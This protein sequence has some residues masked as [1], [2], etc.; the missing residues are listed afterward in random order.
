[1]I[2]GNNNYLIE[3]SQDF[4]D[5]IEENDE[6]DIEGKF[7]KKCVIVLSILSALLILSS[8]GSSCAD[9]SSCLVMGDDLFPVKNLPLTRDDN[10]SLNLQSILDNYRYTENYSAG[11]FDCMDTCTIAT[12]ILQEHGYNPSTM[13]SF[14]LMGSDG[15]S[16]M[17]LSVSDGLGRFAFIETCAFARGRDVLGELVSQ[18]QSA[19]YSSGYVLVDPMRVMQCFGYSEERFLSNLGRSELVSTGPAVH[20]KEGRDEKPGRWIYQ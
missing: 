2:N 5:D 15:G 13:A 4:E 3:K 14:A 17:W 7:V 9:C 10:F 6:A 19:A 1:M 12:R 16:H 18:E 11:R 8:L 20:L